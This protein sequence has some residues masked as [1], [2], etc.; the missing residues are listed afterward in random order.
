[1]NAKKCGLLVAA[2][3][4]YAAC[5]S[6][7]ATVPGSGSLGL[8]GLGTL[9]LLLAVRRRREESQQTA[10]GFTGAAAL[11]GKALFAALAVSVIS[12]LLLASSV[13]AALIP[14]FTLPPISTPYTDITSGYGTVFYNKTTHLLTTYDPDA[15]MDL[16][17]EEIGYGLEKPPSGPI[18]HPPGQPETYNDPYGDTA[19]NIYVDNTGALLNSSSLVPNLSISG[20]FADDGSDDAVLLTGN[21]VQFGSQLLSSSQIFEFYFSVTGGTQAKAFGGI[22][23]QVEMELESPVSGATPSTPSWGANFETNEGYAQSDTVGLAVPEPS[24]FLLLACGALPLGLL[25]WRM[26]RRARNKMDVQ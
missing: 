16:Y 8:L 1:M 9:G 25:R 5:L 24:S 4:L 20:G 23:A 3:I 19:V 10:A 7:A 14:G 11:R 22:G 13:Q 15:E 21:V 26:T 6:S 18:T 2:L 12:W 17:T